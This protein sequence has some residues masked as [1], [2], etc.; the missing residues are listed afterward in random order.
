MI[1]KLGKRERSRVEALASY[2]SKICKG[3]VDCNFNV[4][5]WNY[6]R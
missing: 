1:N 6:R 2:K 3:L 4:A 5:G